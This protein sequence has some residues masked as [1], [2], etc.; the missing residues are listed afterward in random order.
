M[1]WLALIPV[2]WASLAQGPTLPFGFVPQAAS[3][4]CA[5]FT[6]SFSG[7]GALNA[8]YWTNVPSLA[9]GSGTVVQNSGVA[10]V[11]GAYKAGAAVVAGCTPSSTP[12]VQW[13][14]SSLLG[15]GNNQG[16]V[17]DMT[18]SGTGYLGYI[19]ASA[20]HFAVDKCT[21]G[22][23]SFFNTL[24]STCSTFVAGQ[25]VKITQSGS[26]TYTFTV[27]Q[28]GTN[29][30]TLTDSS[31]IAGGFDGL[32]INNGSTTPATNQQVS[33]FSAD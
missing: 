18:T 26:S 10:Q 31:P 25:T 16:F 33:S 11:S 29:C 15:S 13:T 5:P 4:P 2:F 32:Q 1:K 12:Y 28:N 24:G 20:I 21:T 17:L 22:S 3:S 6:D 23:C 7:S 8:T 14:I 19:T 27:Y 9:V 30:G